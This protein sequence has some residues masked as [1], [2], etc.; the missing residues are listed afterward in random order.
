VRARRRVRAIMVCTWCACGVHMHMVCIWCTYGGHS[1]RQR[2][3]GGPAEV[4]FGERF[5]FSNVC[6]H[7]HAYKDT[8]KVTQKD[9]WV[10][11]YTCVS[12]R[13]THTRRGGSMHTHKTNVF[14]REHRT[15]ITLQ[16][17]RLFLLLFPPPIPHIPRPA[18]PDSQ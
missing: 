14:D 15:S 13:H 16:I 3:T 2:D 12:I 6:A 7:T 9:T 1:Y 8:H 17:P 11:Q 5:C 4:A 10:S 18:V